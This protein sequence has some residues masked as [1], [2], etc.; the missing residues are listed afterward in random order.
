MMKGLLVPTPSPLP[1]KAIP[2]FLAIQ[3]NVH[4][5]EDYVEAEA[6][7]QKTLVTLRWETSSPVEEAARAGRAPPAAESLCP[8]PTVE[9]P[10]SIHL[11]APQRERGQQMPQVGSGVLMAQNN[12]RQKREG[13]EWKAGKQDFGH[14]FRE[15]QLPSFGR[16]ALDAQPV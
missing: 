4:Q 3:E 11:P 5:E 2:F 1:P 14:V 16:A 6:G 12:R 8:S 13:R 7:M 15:P 9:I 10:Q